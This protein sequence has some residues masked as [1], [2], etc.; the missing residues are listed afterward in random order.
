[1][2]R[3]GVRP[4][5]GTIL[6]SPSLTIIYALRGFADGMEVGLAAG[7]E[8]KLGS[9][10][11]QEKAPLARSVEVDLNEEFRT[12]LTPRTETGTDRL[13]ISHR[14]NDKKVERSR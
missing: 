1:V 2:Y 11:S 10:G 7:F 4:N 14:G 8:K 5:P 12:T 3:A 6:Y 9:V 13:V